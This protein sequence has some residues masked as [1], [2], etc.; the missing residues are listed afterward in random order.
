MK[1]LIVLALS[2]VVLMGCA[3]AIKDYQTGNTTPLAVNEVSPTTTAQQIGSTI[4]DLPVP[5]AAPIGVAITFLAGIFLTW[6]R[7][8]SIRKTG[9][10]ST[11]TGVS[12]FTGIEQF[13]ANVFAGAFTTITTTPTTAGSVWQRVWKVALATVAS[14]TAVATANPQ[15]MSFLTGHPVLDAVFVGVSA[16]I[17]GLEKALSN[18]PTAVTAA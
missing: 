5:F 11:G 13:V 18:V 17:A 15:V 9:A 14:G 2:A 6:K 10:P 3:Q 1:K 8:V 4:S 16:G 7:G 12:L